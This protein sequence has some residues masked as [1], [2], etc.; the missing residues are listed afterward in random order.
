MAATKLTQELLVTQA[1]I[2]APRGPNHPTLAVQNLGPNPIWAALENSADCV[3]SKSHRIAAGETMSF[4]DLSPEIKVYLRAS[5]A[6][7][8]TGAATII[9][10]IPRYR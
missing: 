10:Q 1:V 3:V 2:E 7:Q 4:T 6:D 5:T 9:T 8:L